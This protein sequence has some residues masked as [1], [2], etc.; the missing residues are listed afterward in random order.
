MERDKLMKIIIAAVI[1]LIAVVVLA[2]QFLGGGAPKESDAA[3]TAPLPA[4]ERQGGGR[5][6]PDG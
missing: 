4:T 6:A 3:D 2:M 5:L 1:G